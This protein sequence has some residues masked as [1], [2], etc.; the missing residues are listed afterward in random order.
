MMIKIILK[1]PLYII[2]FFWLLAVSS[3]YGQGIEKSQLT[4]DELKTYNEAKKEAQKGNYA[5]SNKLFKSLLETQPNFLE[6]I[7]RYATNCISLKEYERSEK[8][9]T[10]AIN[11]DPN[12]EPEAYYSLAL[13]LEGQKN[14]LAA[15]DILNQ[16]ITKV[17]EQLK[18]IEPDNKKLID[19]K[20]EKIK[21][22]IKKRDNF[23]FID[24]AHKNPVPFQPTDLGSGLNSKYSEYTPGLSIDGKSLLFTRMIGDEDFY[25]SLMDSTGSFTRAVPMEGMN[26]YQNEGAHAISADG[27]FIVF[28][29][30]DRRDSYGSCDLYY[31]T[32][33][34]GKWIEAK[35]MG[36]VVNSAAWDSQ[37]TLSADGR[38]LYFTSRRLGTLGAS[39]LWKTWRNDRNAW[40]APVNLGP[41]I[42]TEE[43]DQS[44]FL[45]PDGHT[46]YFRS[47][48][49]PGMG[50]FDIYYSRFNDST[51]TW[52]PP[53]NIGYPINT[54]GDDGALI[55]SLDGK[56]AIFATD[57]NY[58]TMVKGNNLNL[59]SF[60]L[61]PEA[62]PLPTTYVKGNVRDEASDAS[63]QANIKIINLKSKKTIYQF[64]TG[65][66]GYFI[67]GIPTGQ[68][69][70]CIAE[71]P[72]YQ[73]QAIKFDLTDSIYYRPYALEINLKELVKPTKAAEEKPT[74]LQNI[75]YKSGSATLLKESDTELDLLYQLLTSMPTINIHVIGHTDD[76]GN[77]EDN[78][79]LS[80]NRAKSIAT[81]LTQRGILAN[82][83]TTEG[84]GETMPIADNTTEEG[85]KMNR[86]TEFIIK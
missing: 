59:V 85:R 81:A 15:A 2:T 42:N 61:Y 57:M 47:D 76:V 36:H 21:R 19:S 53:V 60:D 16:Y 28:T 50:N 13:A 35:N 7:Y 58:E 6:G 1:S 32:Y 34:E 73:Y 46:L 11:I 27:K 63:I 33:E 72:G 83:I 29:A 74:V 38:T 56:K 14:Y 62:R 54:E 8:L 70:A 24:H 79:L 40:V 30:C 41:T 12:H 67:S 23:R 39:D 26:T 22:S 44:P 25:I 17:E 43:D 37:P 9:F 68:I 55:V 20:E 80:Q 49:R 48:G 84:K 75:F 10:T 64:Q 18:I 45:H 69:Y 31:S 77:E 86:R 51:E 71:A 52:R 5:Q 78:L 4:K 66:E 65:K 82:R 3:S